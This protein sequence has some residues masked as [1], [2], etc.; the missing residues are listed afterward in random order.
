MEREQKMQKLFPELALISD[1]ELRKKTAACIAEAI[2]RGGWNETELENIP[3]TLLVKDKAVPSLI[4]HTRAVTQCAIKMA[5]II[6]RSYPEYLKIDQDILISGGLLHDVGK[7]LEYGKDGGKIGKSR[8]GKILRHPVS[9]AA[10]AY[11]LGLP[12]EVVH[13]IACHSHEGDHVKRS[14]EAIII[15]H[16]DFANFEALGG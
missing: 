4:L 15:L 11:E 16:A 10:L 7:F 13:I 3:F 12:D 14:T 1:E 6:A 2:K 9:G 5:E 8:Q